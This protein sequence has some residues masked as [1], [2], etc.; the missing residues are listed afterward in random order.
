MAKTV[1]FY[2]NTPDDTHCFQAAF[3]M[4]FKY[5]LPDREFSW[6]ELEKMSA[7]VEGLGTWPSAMLIQAQKMGFDVI[8]VEGFDAK[9]FIEEGAN[10]LRQAF[11]EETGAWQVTNSD[12]PQE[13]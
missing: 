3:R 6:E 10:Y 11:G 8:T 9:A 12:I 5:F 2:G 7:K 13:Q 1:P 4:I